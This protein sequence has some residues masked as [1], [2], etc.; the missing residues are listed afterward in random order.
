MDS[1]EA[2]NATGEYIYL[3]NCL[4]CCDLKEILFCSAETTHIQITCYIKGHLGSDDFK[5][6]NAACKSNIR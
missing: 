6:N 5:K 2:R 1:N 3:M 4:E